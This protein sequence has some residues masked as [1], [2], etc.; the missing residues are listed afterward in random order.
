[1]QS[2]LKYSK[3]IPIYNLNPLPLFV[4]QLN[5]SETLMDHLNRKKCF[6]LDHNST[7]QEHFKTACLIGSLLKVYFCPTRTS[8][9]SNFTGFLISI[10]NH[11][12]ETSFL[13]RSI[14]E[15]VGV[16]QSF[17]LLSPLIQKIEVIK[18]PLKKIT[19]TKSY[20]GGDSVLI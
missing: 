10:N 2:I 17:K 19:A 16:E 20:F 18:S 13:L 3:G 6:E 5:C 14:I 7:K 4:K 12:S 8:P 9:V 15:G 1:M 11:S